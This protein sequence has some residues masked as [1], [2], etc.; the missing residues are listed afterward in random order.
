M[1]SLWGI[2][3][4]LAKEGGVPAH[5]IAVRQAPEPPTPQAHGL[6]QLQTRNL[7][8]RSLPAFFLS[9]GQSSLRGLSDRNAPPAVAAAWELAG[10]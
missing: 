4:L 2:D 9:E 8:A 3:G 1:A 7:A 6:P 10:R 5:P